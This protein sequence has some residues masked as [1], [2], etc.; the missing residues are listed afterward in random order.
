MT[1]SERDQHPR[2][3]SREDHRTDGK[4]TPS[5]APQHFDPVLIS[6]L[7]RRGITD[8]KAREL[9]ANLKPGQEK[10]LVAQLEYA[11]QTVE[12]LRGT[13]HQ[14]RNPAGF[15]ISMIEHNA[16]LPENF[17]TS[18]ERTARVAREREEGER[19]AATEARQEL[20][21]EYDEYRDAETDHYIEANAAA[22]EALKDAKWKEDRERFAFTTESM[23][24]MAARFEMQKQITL[25]TFEEFLQHKKQGTDF[26]L[27]PVGPSPA[28]KL[29]TSVAEPEDMLAADEMREATVK[30]PVTAAEEPIGSSGDKEAVELAEV[31][32]EVKTPVGEIEGVNP[33]SD[34]SPVITPESA[35]AMPEPTQEDAPAPSKPEEQ[36]LNA[37]PLM[38]ELISDP[39]Q[40]G[41][42]GVAGSGEAII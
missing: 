27:K 15:I 3:F 21:W 28:P 26:S 39:P 7:T 20:E 17:E 37:E 10:Q 30:Q 40:D 18:A 31:V 38:I 16:M 5:S 8:K 25:L 29:A 23:A 35:S 32:P 41:Q 12:Q 11:E 33:A 19:R 42:L 4:L 9:L 2:S 1:I 6:E 36:T 22:F 24:R 34:P 14:V 13:P